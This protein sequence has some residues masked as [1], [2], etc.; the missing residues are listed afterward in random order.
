[1]RKILPLTAVFT[2]TVIDVKGATELKV[3]TVFVGLG[4]KLTIKNMHRLTFT[5][6][7]S[8]NITIHGRIVLLRAGEREEETRTRE[9]VEVR[10]GHLRAKDL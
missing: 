4:R 7:S 2:D 10:P 8:G 1:M 5:L 3:P 6:K 9:L